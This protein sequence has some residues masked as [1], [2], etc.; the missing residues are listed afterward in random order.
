[1]EYLWF[2]FWTQSFTVVSPETRSIVETSVEYSMSPL[3]GRLGTN[4]PNLA[5]RNRSRPKNV[6]QKPYKHSCVVCLVFL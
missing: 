4:E 1:M 5:P 3:Y 6:S 2:S